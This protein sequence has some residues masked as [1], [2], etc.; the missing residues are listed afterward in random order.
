MKSLQ[1]FHHT[2][3]REEFK[4][5]FDG[6]LF[7]FADLFPESERKLFCFFFGTFE[8]LDPGADQVDRDHEGDENSE[9]PHA[10]DDARLDGFH[11]A[12]V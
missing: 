2:T 12:A 3:K 11:V 7:F 10:L 1:H 9:A 5:W 6:F 4:D 8:R